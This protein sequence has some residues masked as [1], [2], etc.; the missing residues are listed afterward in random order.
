MTLAV[1]H[2]G[3]FRSRLACTIC[4]F[5]SNLQ[6]ESGTSMTIGAGLG[7]GRK[8]Q[9]EHTFSFGYSGW[10]FLDYLSRRSV[11]SGNFPVGQTKIALLFTIQPKIPHFFCKR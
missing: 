11:Y 7:T 5:L 6:R 10:E 4:A 3:N 2:Y 1:Y 8:R 9:K